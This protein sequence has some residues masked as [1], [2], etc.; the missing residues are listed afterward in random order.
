MLIDSLPFFFFFFYR[1]AIRSLIAQLIITAL[2]K[3]E[4]FNG[5]EWPV[6]ES[7]LP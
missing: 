6:T 2:Y 1:K 5:A 4:L 7:Q 3:P